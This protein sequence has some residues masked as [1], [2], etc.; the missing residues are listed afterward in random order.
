VGFVQNKV[1]LGQVV[2]FKYFPV[3]TLLVSILPLLLVT[4]LFT[5]HLENVHVL[6]QEDVNI[7]QLK[8]NL[9]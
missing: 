1:I 8:G 7:Y 3:F 6:M 4:A 2:L 5:V 9:K